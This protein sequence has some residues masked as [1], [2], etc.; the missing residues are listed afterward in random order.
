[1]ILQDVRCKCTENESA[2]RTSEEYTE[3]AEVLKQFRSQD[4][5][6]SL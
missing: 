4:G 3:Q 1:M 5:K 2:L 6:G